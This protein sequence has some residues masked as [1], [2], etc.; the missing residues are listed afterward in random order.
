MRRI[1]IVLGFGFAAVAS[2][3]T[4]PGVPWKAKSLQ[5]LPKDISKEDIKALMKK[6]AQ[7]LGVDCDHCHKLP[8]MDQDTDKKQAARQMMRMVRDVNDHYFKG[9]PKVECLTCHRGEAK[10]KL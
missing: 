1:A 5:V 7:A 4:P 3:Q 6:Q 9:K 2:A 10:P 8:D